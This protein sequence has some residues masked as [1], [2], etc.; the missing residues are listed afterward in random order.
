MT[1]ITL[2][3]DNQRLEVAWERNA[4][5]RALQKLAAQGPVDVRMSRYGGFE[6]V[7]DL[8]FSLP[9]AD[10]QTETEAGDIV[11]YQGRQIVVFF[12]P[13]A[14][15]YT[16]LG[17][18]AGKTAGQLKEMLDRRQVRLTLQSADK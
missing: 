14:W 10:E 12:A 5:V 1:G 18:I 8:G 3:I 15:A 13:N 6:Q 11:L 2:S 7:G 9:M 4:S 16:R 17:R